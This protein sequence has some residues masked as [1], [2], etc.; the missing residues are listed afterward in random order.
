MPNG[1]NTYQGK[2]PGVPDQSWL[3][4]QFPAH[5]LDRSAQKKNVWLDF[6]AS[7]IIFV[8]TVIFQSVTT[9]NS[10]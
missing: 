10:R 3:S 4:I 2:R 9:L 6:L 7:S 8:K 5:S 1:D